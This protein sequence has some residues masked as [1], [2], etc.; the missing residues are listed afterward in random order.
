MPVRGTA[1]SIHQF[2]GSLLDDEWYGRIQRG[3]RRGGDGR[4]YRVCS[5]VR[6]LYS[7]QYAMNPTPHVV[8][9][10]IQAPGAAPILVPGQVNVQLGDDAA[11]D[12]VTALTRLG[13]RGVSKSRCGRLDRPD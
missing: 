12:E 2:G 3:D 7:A 9:N 8:A 10:T 4:E 11:G 6:T 1:P 5:E 13:E